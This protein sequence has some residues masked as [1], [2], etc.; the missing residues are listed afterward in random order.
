MNGDRLTRLIGEVDDRF[1]EEAMA[2]E[3][4]KWRYWRWTGGLVAAAAVTL[5][6]V[7]WDGFKELIPLS[8]RSSNMSVAYIDEEDID[9]RMSSA[10]LVEM[11]EDE[12]FSKWNPA[13]VRG[14]VKQIDHIELDFN[15]QEEYQSIVTI[16]VTDVYRGEIEPGSTIQVLTVAGVGSEVSQS[17]A[18][19]VSELRLGME[20][21][22]MPRRHDASH[23]W[24]QNGAS[25]Q[26]M[27][28]SD[29]GFPDGERYMFL[30]KDEGLVFMRDAYPSMEGAETLDDI[31]EV[32][33]SKLE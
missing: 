21:I 26:V 8:D 14:V 22:F 29:Y 10:D 33:I 13:V 1:V 23:V 18:S 7:T 27:D 20:G 32:L 25:L 9:V 17:E 5:F 31:E 24:S 28:V 19:V 15:G 4:K 12:L 6:A 2:V 30:E 3:V 16:G 11:S